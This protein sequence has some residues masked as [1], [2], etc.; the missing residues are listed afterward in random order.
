MELSA[1]SHQIV[2]EYYEDRGQAGIRVWWQQ[3]GGTTPPVTNGWQGEYYG[4]VGLEGNPL[5]VRDDSEINFDWGAGAPASWLPSDNFSVRWSRQ[6]DFAAGY[7]NLSV[8]S[9]DGVRVWVNNQLLIDQWRE[10]A[11]ELHTADGVY[12]SGTNQ[13]T[14][15]Y[16]ERSGF[17]RVHFW[18]SPGGNAPPAPATVIVDDDDPG[19]IKGGAPTSWRSA[20]VGHDG[21]L[22]WTRNNDYT[23]SNYNWGRWHPNL[24]PGRYEVFAYIPPQFASTENARYWVRH[25]DAFSLRVVDQSIYYGEWVSLGTYDFDGDGDEYVSLSDVT[26]ERYLS[27]MIAFDAVKW[28][29]R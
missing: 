2:V 12:L 18:V 26:Y 4:N 15:E 21:R 16:Y 17:A 5:L 25:A 1:G 28:V 27:R 7:Y 24:A 10:M 29:R 6:T 8:R 13:L 3:L 20:S 9:D 14:V 22:T 19:F 23:R 11:N